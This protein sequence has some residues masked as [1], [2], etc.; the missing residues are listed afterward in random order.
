MRMDDGTLGPMAD[1][2]VDFSD[3]FVSLPVPEPSAALLFGMGLSI[4]ASRRR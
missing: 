2:N 1:P 4:L 3:S